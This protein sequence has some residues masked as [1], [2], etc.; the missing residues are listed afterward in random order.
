MTWKRLAPLQRALRW[1]RRLLAAVFA[2]LAAYCV[3]AVLA[4][5][6]PGV[7]VLA[8]ARPVPGGTALTADDL[9]IL[10]LPEAAVPEGALT[11]PAEAVGRTV[12]APLPA[13]AVL[14]SSALTSSGTLVARG[15]VALPVALAGDAPVALLR[16]GDRIDLLGAGAD[17]AVTVLAAG[18]RVVTIPAVVDSG[19]VLGG[20]APVILVDLAPAQAAAVVAAATFAPVA[21]ALR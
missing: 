9:R 11:A 4:D 7:P 15:R 6:D 10:T 5:E 20:G 18:V 8:A 17:G 2:A 3:L 13:R 14:T 19:G 1:H 12:V 16:V 21:F